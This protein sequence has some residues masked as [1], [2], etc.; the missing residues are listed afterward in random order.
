MSSSGKRKGLDTKDK[1]RPKRNRRPPQYFSYNETGEVASVTP[2]TL[3][4]A[5]PTANAVFRRRRAPPPAPRPQRYPHVRRRLTF[6]EG[7]DEEEVSQ[8]TYRNVRRV[9]PPSPSSLCILDGLQDILA[10]DDD[11]DEVTQQQTSN[12][13]TDTQWIPALPSERIVVNGITNVSSGQYVK[14]GDS[15]LI[16]RRQDDTILRGELSAVYMD[17]SDCEWQLELLPYYKPSSLDPSVPDLCDNEY[18]HWLRGPMLHTVPLR[19]AVVI[20]KLNVVT[21]ARP[22][23]IYARDTICVKRHLTSDSSSWI[24]N[25]EFYRQMDRN[26]AAMY[27]SSNINTINVTT[28]A[29]EDEERSTPTNSLREKITDITDENHWQGFRYMMFGMTDQPEY[30]SYMQYYVHDQCITPLLRVGNDTNYAGRNML[31]N[32]AK[33]GNYEIHDSDGSPHRTFCIICNK[34]TECKY[35]LHCHH[36]P[37]KKERLSSGCASRLNSLREF[38]TFE[39]DNCGKW[40]ETQEETYPSMFQTLYETFE[41]ILSRAQSATKMY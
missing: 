4:S 7:E 21:E 27:Q 25:A 30:K 36:N 14:V 34:F 5:T 23:N 38:Y 18:C 32:L 6:S 28:D 10:C 19:D 2:T 1:R 22:M 3:T 39:R 13:N 12:N 15:L 29:N 40:N 24:S 37:E 33:E 9:Y 11:D 8:T 31:H 41:G 20:K 16:R 17:V 35:L 26:T